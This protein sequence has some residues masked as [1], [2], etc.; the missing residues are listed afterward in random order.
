MHKSGNEKKSLDTF[1]CFSIDTHN[2]LEQTKTF[3]LAGSISLSVS[4]THDCVCVSSFNLIST[5][6]VIFTRSD[7]HIPNIISTS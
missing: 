4:L 2:L 3:R 7:I 6:L 5:F 1:S